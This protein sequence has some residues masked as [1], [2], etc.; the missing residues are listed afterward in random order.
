VKLISATTTV[1][2]CISVLLVIQIIQWTLNS[3]ELIQY[4]EDTI[5]IFRGIWLINILLLN[6]PLIV[7]FNVLR[8]KQL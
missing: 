1:L 2:S 8:K 6:I 7:F 5:W 4:T 3:F